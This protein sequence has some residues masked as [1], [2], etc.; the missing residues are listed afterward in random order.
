[1]HFFP[2]A[3][4]IFVCSP[5][6]SESQRRPLAIT[7]HTT[8]KQSRPKKIE[9]RHAPRESV[10]NKK[11]AT[12]ATKLKK[13]VASV[14]FWNERCSNPVRTLRGAKASFL[15]G[16]KKELMG[17]HRP[18]SVLACADLPQHAHKVRSSR[19]L[20][21]AVRTSGMTGRFRPR[22]FQTQRHLPEAFAFCL[23]TVTVLCSRLL[24]SRACGAPASFSPSPSPVDRTWSLL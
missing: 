24:Q 20:A 17:S 2:T 22:A 18:S 7:I 1:M 15:T 16:S 8:H 19:A 12:A 9:K 3:L 4:A 11:P 5:I 10:T 6:N 14:S 23:R 21:P 13:R